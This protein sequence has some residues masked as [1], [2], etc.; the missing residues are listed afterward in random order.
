M[1]K[2]T[3]AQKTKIAQSKGSLAKI[4]KAIRP[5][6]NHTVKTSLR[7]SIT[8]GTV[9]IV[10][11]GAQKG[12]RVVFLKQI[13]SGQLLVTG[14]YKLNGCPLTRIDQTLVIPEAALKAAESVDDKFFA[15]IAEAKRSNEFFSAD[16]KV[17]VN[18]KRVEVQKAIDAALLP[19]V[20]AA[21]EDLVGYLGSFFSLTHNM[22]PHTLKF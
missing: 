18:P 4:C 8:P 5:K 12:K 2:L 10:L 11:A 1:V 21:G 15:A 7:K 16:K 3:A 22:K 13:P 19:A 14:P 17:Q 9:L 6:T 20:K